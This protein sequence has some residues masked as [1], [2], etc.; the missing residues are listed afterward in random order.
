M[1][2]AV[3]F[4]LLLLLFSFGSGLVGRLLG[5]F[6]SVVVVYF[7]GVVLFCFALFRLSV[8]LFDCLFIYIV[9]FSLYIVCNFCLENHSIPWVVAGPGK[10]PPTESGNG[11]RGSNVMEEGSSGNN[12]GVICPLSFHQETSVQKVTYFSEKFW[13]RTSRTNGW[14]KVNKRSD[15]YRQY[16]KARRPK[17]TSLPPTST[18]YPYVWSNR[19]KRKRE[20][21]REREKEIVITNHWTSCRH[22]GRIN[23]LILPIWISI[24]V[25][26]DNKS[27]RSK[28]A[29]KKGA[30]LAMELVESA[31]ERGC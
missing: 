30:S 18:Y 7:W 3:L 1:V 25:R 19:N 6:G 24:S 23:R 15:W 9:C 28:R 4:L 13:T 14:N 16:A 21:E 22:A 29:R 11:K 27:E 20:G 12:T 17:S 2:T 8:G 10:I 26:G 31:L 5:G